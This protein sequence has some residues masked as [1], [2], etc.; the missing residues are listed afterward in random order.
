[1]AEGYRG[2]FA[3]SPTGP[4]HFG[5]LV[6]AAGSWLHARRHGGKWLVRI[7]DIDESRTVPGA[8]FLILKTLAAY[9][10]DWDEE[11]VWQTQRHSRYARAIETLGD[12][13]FPCACSRKEAGVQYPGT[14][15]NGIAP[16]RSARAIRLLVPDENSPLTD[17]ILRRADGIYAY[18]LAV[19]V[20]DAAQGITDVVRGADLLDSTARQIFL[21][22][23][24]GLPTPRYLHLPIMTNAAGEKLS[25]QTKAPPVD[26]AGDPSVLLRA[27]QFLGM[28]P[29]PAGSCRELLAAT[30][31]QLR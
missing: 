6:T 2:R 18:Q 28:G 23:Q 20:D 5:S 21:Q 17:F 8:D 1:M 4:L 13:C 29:S 11:V 7:E 22:R 19:V 12:K 14:C 30:L 31:S 16:G 9:G 3:P 25:K 15:R 10:L 24:L 26:P 27:L